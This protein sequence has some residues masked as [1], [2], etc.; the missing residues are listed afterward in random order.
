M[1]I[2]SSEKIPET[3]WA[4]FAGLFDAE[5]CIEIK[6]RHRENVSKKGFTYQRQ[7]TLSDMHFQTLEWIRQTLQMGHIQDHNYKNKP[8][9]YSIRFKTQELKTILPK[10]LPYLKETK[11][12]TKVMIKWLDT[13][14][15]DMHANNASPEKK[16]ER[17]AIYE[18][19]IQ[20]VFREKNWLSEYP[21][22]NTRGD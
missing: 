20:A 10:L 5:G 13:L 19:F 6:K 14:G 15:D 18:E 7:V 16:K 1:K 17:E 3:F 21:D 8:T 2:N 9:A 4:Y 22:L 11:E 12:R